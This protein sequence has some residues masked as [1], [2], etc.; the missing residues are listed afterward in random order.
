MIGNRVYWWVF[1][2]EYVYVFM[3]LGESLSVFLILVFFVIMKFLKNIVL[4]IFEY[5]KY[6]YNLN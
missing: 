6:V 5:G 2:W 4:V 1:Y 3:Y